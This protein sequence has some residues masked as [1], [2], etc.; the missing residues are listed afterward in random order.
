MISTVFLQTFV[1]QFKQL[2]LIDMPTWIR[3]SGIPVLILKCW[4]WQLSYSLPS[5]FAYL[6][7]EVALAVH[8][9]NICFMR[10]YSSSFCFLQRIQD[11][12]LGT[13]VVFPPQEMFL[14]CILYKSSKHMS[15]YFKGEVHQK[16]LNK[17]YLS[18]NST[19]FWCQFT[20]WAY[21][22]W[23]ATYYIDFWKL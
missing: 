4:P 2:L 15:Y 9:C 10:N 5:G 6:S 16:N 13:S 1:S 18:R 11:V 8:I 20:I 14:I 17:V 12:F 19:I 22:V 21:K 7:N 3:N 23:S